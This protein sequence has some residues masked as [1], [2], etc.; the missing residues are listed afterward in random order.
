MFNIKKLSC[1]PLDID[2]LTL[3]MRIVDD[4][5]LKVDVGHFSIVL[6]FT[7]HIVPSFFVH[8]CILLEIY[9]KGLLPLV[10]TLILGV[11]IGTSDENIVKL[12]K[13]SLL[14]T[15]S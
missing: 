3:I 9:T 5:T 7:I 6:S 15:K 12:S 2:G 4:L 1:V 11:P 14:N 13:I 8:F 10:N